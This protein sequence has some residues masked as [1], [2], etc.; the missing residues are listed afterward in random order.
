MQYNVAQLLKEPV[1][2]TR[3]YWVDEKDVSIDGE[4]RVDVQ[5]EVTFLWTHRSILVT[6]SL[7]TNLTGV[8]GRCLEPFEYDLSLEL[9]EEYFPTID[10]NTGLPV[11]P[12]EE[13]FTLDQNHILDLAE[14]VR[15]SI[16]MATPMKLVCRAE[17]KGLCPEC[18]VNLNYTTCNCAAQTTDLRWAKLKVLA[19]PKERAETRK[20]VK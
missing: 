18:G 5:G 15:Q 2:S 13:G 1:G 9:E 10:I 8:C 11:E 19:L 7:T 17:C 3:T 20:G 12:P 14:A 6:G 4:G 16:V